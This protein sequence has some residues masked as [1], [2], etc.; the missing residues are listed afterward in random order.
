MPRLAEIGVPVEAILIT[1]TARN[2][3][4]RLPVREG[5]SVLVWFARLPAGTTPAEAWAPLAGWLE[6]RLVR[7]LETLHLAPTAGSRLR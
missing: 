3:Y 5:E 7:P 4:P 1:E 6:G 2:T